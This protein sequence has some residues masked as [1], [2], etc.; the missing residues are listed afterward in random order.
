MDADM[1]AVTSALA[2]LTDA[3]LHALIDAT[4]EAP[5]TAPGLFAWIV[6]ACDWE[7]N[8]RHG[9]DYALRSPA[10]AIPPEEGAAS[11]YAAMTMRSMFAQDNRASATLALLHAIV[12]LLSGG[13]RSQ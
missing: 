8:R 4:N 5:R 12:E 3:E 2:E 11:I 7:L 6:G 10:V 1:N 9:Q 13:E